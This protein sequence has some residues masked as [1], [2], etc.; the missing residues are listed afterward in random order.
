MCLRKLSTKVVRDHQY[1]GESG[2]I[3]EIEFPRGTSLYGKESEFYYRDSYKLNSKKLNYDAKHIYYGIFGVLPKPA[4]W[5]MAFRNAIMKWFGFS[6]G[7][8]DTNLL[9]ENIEEGKKAGFLTIESVTNREV[10]SGSYE[11]HMDIWISVLKLSDSEFAVS[12]LVNMKTNASRVYL[13]IIKPFHKV[14]AK[15]A[16]RHAINNKRI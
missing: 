9:L 16:I 12:T 2:L 14:L 1:Q 15:Y 4:Q 13:K 6:V 10:V 11:K 7:N 8:F 3:Q 5:M